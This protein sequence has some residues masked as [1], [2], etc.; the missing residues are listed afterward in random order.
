ME[1]YRQIVRYAAAF[2][3]VQQASDLR[4]D[5]MDLTLILRRRKKAAQAKKAAKP[6]KPRRRIVHH[7]RKAAPKT[8]APASKQRKP[9]RAP[10]VKPATAAA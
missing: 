6:K 5:P 8:P 4:S 3:G 9:G 1:T 2:V 7:R 10:K